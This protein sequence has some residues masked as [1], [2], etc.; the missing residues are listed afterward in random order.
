MG[1]PRRVFLSHTGELRD[2]PPGR[3]FVDAAEEHVGYIYMQDDALPNPWDT[4]PPYFNDLVGA[5]SS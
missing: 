1:V 4:L 3:S 2:F 5:L